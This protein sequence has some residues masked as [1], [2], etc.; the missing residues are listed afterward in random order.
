MNDWKLALVL[1][2][3]SDDGEIAAGGTI[4]RL[5]EMG[6]V[7]WYVYF[8]LPPLDNQQESPI[9]ET[10]DAL[11][12]LGVYSLPGLSA[13]P[14][15]L[16]KVMPKYRQ[17]I[18]DRIVF[19][20]RNLNPDVVFCPSSFDTHQDHEVIYKEAFRACKKC[21]ILGFDFP[22]N[23]RTGR[24]DCFVKL[25]LEH[26]RQKVA[27]IQQHKSQLFRPFMA[28]SAI[29]ALAHSRGILAGSEY[30]EAFEVIRWIW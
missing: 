6:V 23:E 1:N 17:E 12:L 25:G 2:A 11:T 24:K 9:Q 5:I 8:A 21:T 16:N 14:E 30:A 28:E 3:H 10:V 7:V 15:Y 20:Y 4:I 26:V 27:A 13:P 19:L 22:W 29:I 18:L